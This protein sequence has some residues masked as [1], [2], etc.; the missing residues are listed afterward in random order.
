M[1]TG[2]WIVLGIIVA[3][4]I[5]AIIIY[6]GLVALRNRYKNAYSQIDVQLKRRYDLIPNL[7]ETAKGYLKHERE[8]LEAVI[9]ARNQALAAAQAA[10]AKPGDPA[11]M[12]GLG[13]AEG[14]LA[15]LLGRLFAL[16]EAYPD[17]KAN[18]NMIVLH[19][20]LASTENKVA[21]ARQ[22]FN[23]SVMEYNIKRESFPDSIVAGPFRF[24]P[25]ELLQATESGE[26]RK[27]PK[28]SFT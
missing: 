15:G 16:A 9:K 3:I 26:E 23:D 5:W 24:D 27:A 20:E 11:A 18:Q 4:L 14:Q 13:Q 17:L 2:G 8:T 25:A 21:F 22:A 12:Q 10:A 19:E 1:G 28:V 6:N 7:V